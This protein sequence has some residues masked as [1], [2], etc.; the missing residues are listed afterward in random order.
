MTGGG[1][2]GDVIAVVISILLGASGNGSGRVMARGRDTSHMDRRG[3]R[4][5]WTVAWARTMPTGPLASQ[6]GPSRGMVAGG[7]DVGERRYVDLHRD[8]G[9]AGGDEAT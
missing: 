4:R 9:G 6:P 1:K 5:G 7:D 2:V 3:Q 8:E